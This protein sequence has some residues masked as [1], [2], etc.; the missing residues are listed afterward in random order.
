MKTHNL[1]KRENSREVRKAKESEGKSRK[2]PTDEAPR[3]KTPNDTRL[4]VAE[5]ICNRKP[6]NAIAKKLRVSPK[7]ISEV[8]KEIADGTIKIAE[9]GK[10]TNHKNSELIEIG[11]L[12]K[13]LQMEILGAAHLE[14]KSPQDLIAGLIRLDCKMRLKELSLSQLEPAAEFLE[15]ALQ[16]G[17]TSDQLVDILTRLQ[18]SSISDL[19]Q[20]SMDSLREFLECAKSRNLKPEHV[21]KIALRTEDE[22]KKIIQEAYDLGYQHGIKHYKAWLVDFAVDIFKNADT[23][24]ATLRSLDRVINL[25]EQKAMED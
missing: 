19:D 3:A 9:D 8:K 13:P 15:K 10:A 21:I 18:N 25:A 4:I 14:R 22:W 17:W 7:T 24:Y 6:Y 16:R 12:P 2:V 20:Q 1:G 5:M 11:P 23:A